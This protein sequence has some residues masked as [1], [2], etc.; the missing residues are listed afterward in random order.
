MLRENF[1]QSAN[2]TYSDMQVMKR[3]RNYLRNQRS[4]IHD[5]DIN[6]EVAKLPSISIL[7]SLCHVTK[8]LIDSQKKI[9]ARTHAITESNKLTQS[10]LA[11]KGFEHTS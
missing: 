3:R 5:T 11:T 8:W 10:K 2:Q 7:P 9:M 1:I 6:A 4:R